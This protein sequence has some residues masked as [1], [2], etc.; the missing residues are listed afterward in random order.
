M[1]DGK[2][3]TPGELSVR[4]CAWCCCRYGD[5]IVT[6]L[7]LEFAILAKRSKGNLVPD[8]RCDFGYGFFSVEDVPKRRS[9][10]RSK[11][12]PHIAI[13]VEF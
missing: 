9:R 5:L 6:E 10:R 13:L 1:S 2:A 12:R 7:D 4:A 11:N 3:Q 8:V